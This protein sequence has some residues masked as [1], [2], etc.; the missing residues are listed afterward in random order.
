[1]RSFR[2]TI[3]TVAAVAVLAITGCSEPL[4]PCEIESNLDS[5]F[6]DG[7]WK[8]ELINGQPI[9]PNGFKAD[10]KNFVKSVTMEFHTLRVAGGCL[11]PSSMSGSVVARYKLVDE[12]GFAK[13]SK[14]YS[15][16]FEYE[17][18]PGDISFRVDTE[19]ASGDRIAP[20]VIMVN[21]IGKN[22]WAPM[23]VTLTR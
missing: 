3:T 11:V 14:S 10:N 15:A 2:G 13:D 5:D 7:T 4:N 8:S 23:T 17:P 22:G 9:P 19:L 18:K 6:L 21:P 12:I 20:Q 16:L 1:M